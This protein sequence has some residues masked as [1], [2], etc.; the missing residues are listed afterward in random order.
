MSRKQASG[1]TR[2]AGGASGF[3]VTSLWPPCPRGGRGGVQRWRTTIHG[4]LNGVLTV[5]DMHVLNRSCYFKF[6]KKKRKIREVKSSRKLY[7]ISILCTDSCK[8]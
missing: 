5:T 8:A 4:I 1:L 6:F 2:R 3:P 7:S